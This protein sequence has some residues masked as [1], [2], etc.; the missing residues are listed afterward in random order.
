MTPARLKRVLLSLSDP[1]LRVDWLTS[2]LTRLPSADAAALLST[3][4]E[5]AEAQ[6][7]DAREALLTIAIFCADS[8]N[9]VRVDALRDRAIDGA[10]FGLERLL[11]RA[12]TSVRPPPVEEPRV[13]D[14]GKGRELTLGERK[15]LARRP[16]RRA[17]DRLLGDPH[18]M[19]IRQLL[20]NPK[21]IEADAIRL[22]AMRPARVEVIRE[23]VRAHRW[24]GRPRVRQAI[25]LNP[26]TPSEIAV[27]LVCLC[28]RE[29]LHDVLQSTD[30]SLV[31]RATAQELLQR[32]P[33][34]PSDA[35]RTIH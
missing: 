12:P 27:P 19:V 2:E 24:M 15:S 3:V 10:L 34:M 8:N 18:P 22:A 33:P 26:G 6:D 9:A 7:P 1:T 23:L 5:E 4:I 17:F 31:L 21:M 32:R 14:Y 30:T 28:N 20:E 29:E 13:P 25:V 35:P 11:R 16:D